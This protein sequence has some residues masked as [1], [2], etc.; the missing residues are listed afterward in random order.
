MDFPIATS[1]SWNGLVMK[2]NILWLDVTN[3]NSLSRL[4]IYRSSLLYKISQVELHVIKKHIRSFFLRHNLYKGFLHV[5]MRNWI[6]GKTK[7][8]IKNKKR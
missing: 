2:C 4:Y 3:L 7:N 8:K 1:Q 5:C 6:V